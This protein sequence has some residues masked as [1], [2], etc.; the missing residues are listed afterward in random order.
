MTQDSVPVQN[1]ITSSKLDLSHVYMCMYVCMYVCIM[2]NM[3]QHCI[4]NCIFCIILY[5]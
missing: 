1:N 4:D 3:H 5:K 2:Y